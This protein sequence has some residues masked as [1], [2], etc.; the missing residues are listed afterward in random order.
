MWEKVASGTSVG[1]GPR[2]CPSG[3]RP[4]GAAPTQF[5]DAAEGRWRQTNPVGRSANEGQIL[6]NKGVSSDSP[7]DR[8][9]ETKPIPAGKEASE[10]VAASSGAPKG[11]A[12]VTAGG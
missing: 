3:G 7:Q 4:R 5:Q 12:A 11:L 1:A 9:E 8:L 2:A 10:W 6:D